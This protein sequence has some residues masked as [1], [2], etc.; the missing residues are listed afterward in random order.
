MSVSS[1]NLIAFLTRGGHCAALVPGNELVLG[2]WLEE[3][4]VDGRFHESEGTF[5]RSNGD[6]TRYWLTG[7]ENDD[8]LAAGDAVKQT[9]QMRLCRVLVDRFSHEGWTW[10]SRSGPHKY[11]RDG[12][13][14]REAMWR[15]DDGCWIGHVAVGRRVCVRWER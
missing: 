3:S 11:L 2:Q 7:A 15:G 8:L 6:Q 4:I 14:P 5:C 10:S 1:S 13:A 12:R 9:Q